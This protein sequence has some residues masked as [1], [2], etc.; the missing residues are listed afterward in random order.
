MFKKL[1]ITLNKSPELWDRAS[2]FL[3]RKP[4]SK[5]TQ[6]SAAGVSIGRTLLTDEQ[7]S[8]RLRMERHINA[9]SEQGV[10]LL[11]SIDEVTASNKDLIYLIATFQHFIREQ[12]DVVLIIAGLPWN[13][14]QIFQQESISFLRRAFRRQLDPI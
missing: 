2:E 1:R 14:L 10:S 11:L 9:L 13:V 4:G 6:V 3:S 5:L 12:R 8:W 7:K